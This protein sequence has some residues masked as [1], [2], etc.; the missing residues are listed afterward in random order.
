LSSHSHQFKLYIKSYSNHGLQ[1]AKPNVARAERVES[2]VNQKSRATTKPRLA[3]SS[4]ADPWLVTK[5]WLIAPLTGVF[6]NPV[7]NNMK[8]VILFHT[9][10]TMDWSNLIYRM[11][12]DRESRNPSDRIDP[13]QIGLAICKPSQAIIE[14]FSTSTLQVIVSLDLKKISLSLA[15]QASQSPKNSL[16]KFITL[17]FLMCDLRDTCLSSL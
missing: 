15:K 17:N 12:S 11:I 14:K 16:K 3:K 6:A 13:L 8:Y 5:E 9:E 7:K 4:R 1:R 10:L 2:L